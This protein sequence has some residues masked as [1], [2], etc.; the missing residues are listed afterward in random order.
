MGG[1]RPQLGEFEADCGHVP[2]SAHLEGKCAQELKSFNSRNSNSK[3][4]PVITWSQLI[5]VGDKDHAR[6]MRRLLSR[7]AERLDNGHRL[8]GN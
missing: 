2:P 7:C 3:I 6:G 5:S 4:G 1:H 8:S